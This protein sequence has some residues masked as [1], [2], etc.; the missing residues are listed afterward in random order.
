MKGRQSFHF[1]NPKLIIPTPILHAQGKDGSLLPWEVSTLPSVP[2]LPSLGPFLTQMTWN[3][4]RWT[5]APPVTRHR[6]GAQPNWTDL[7]D[8]GYGVRQPAHAL[9]LPWRSVT[10]QRKR[11]RL[12]LKFFESNL[13]R[14][15]GTEKK[16]KISMRTCVC[17]NIMSEPPENRALTVLHPYS[18][19]IPSS[20]IKAWTSAALN[21][22]KT[23]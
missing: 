10:A 15:T 6:Q 3:W 19:Q 1:F 21:D 7:S 14:V 16:R 23:F 2:Q 11:W 5:N 4:V 13:K 20:V 18:N 22:A 17:I 12:L 8:W 9:P